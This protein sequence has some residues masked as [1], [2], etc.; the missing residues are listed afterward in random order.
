MSDDYTITPSDNDLGLGDSTPLSM[1]DGQFHCETCD[2][3]L[4]YGGRGRHPRF[5]DDHKPGKATSG[6]RVGTSMKAIE[7]SLVQMYGFLGMGVAMFDPFAGMTITSDAEKLAAS[8]IVLANS[9]PKV[10]KFLQKATTG[11]GIGA[12]LIAHAMV[13]VPIALH[14]G[15]LPTRLGANGANR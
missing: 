14:H 15:V 9:N 6:P 4:Y 10:K 13:A 1:T 7:D 2:T 8:W 12:V 11:G 3:V 5:C